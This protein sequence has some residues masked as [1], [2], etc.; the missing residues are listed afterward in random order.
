MLVLLFSDRHSKH[1][2]PEPY[3]HTSQY[4][5]YVINVFHIPQYTI[6]YVTSQVIVRIRSYTFV[7][8]VK[9]VSSYI[10]RSV[11]VEG[12]GSGLG[13]LPHPFYYPI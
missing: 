13:G 5:R 6:V 3:Y 12:L 2:E 8:V 9:R 7:F 11:V 4:Y 1:G 10:L